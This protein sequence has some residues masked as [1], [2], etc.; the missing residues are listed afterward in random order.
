MTPNSRMPESLPCSRRFR[1]HTI[2]ATQGGLSEQQPSLLRAGMGY[3]NPIVTQLR[4]WDRFCPQVLQSSVKHKIA[5][6][7]PDEDS[8]LWFLRGRAGDS[9]VL[10]RRCGGMVHLNSASTG[11]ISDG[12]GHIESE[13]WFSTHQ[14]VSY[15]SKGIGCYR[16]VYK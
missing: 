4:P 10:F 7:R 3:G 2:T 12:R 9:S 11:S 5:N 8:I 6:I 14:L 1:I 16:A 15:A 13:R